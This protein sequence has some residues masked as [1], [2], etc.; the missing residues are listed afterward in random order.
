MAELGL[1]KV[2]DLT[3]IGLAFW[4][5]GWFLANSFYSSL[6]AIP[7]LVGLPL[8]VLAAFE[9][10]WGIYLRSR[11]GN[12]KI[13]GGLHETHPIVVARSAVLA[14]ASALVGV[15]TAGLWAGMLIY[16]IPKVS[17]GVRAA[18]IDLPGVIIGLVAGIV[19]ASAAVWLER[20]CVAP[21]QSPLN[22][23]G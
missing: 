2:R 14:K 21:P 4:V 8:L 16:L 3:L 12:T 6:P 23:G 5:L 20:G 7:L 11:I 22:A 19:L 17:S 9:A 1:T 15:L 13:G 18:V 10:G